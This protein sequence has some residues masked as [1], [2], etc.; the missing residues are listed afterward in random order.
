MSIPWWLDDGGYV[1]P[2]YCKGCDW[3][4]D[5]REKAWGGE[6]CSFACYHAAAVKL[7]ACVDCGQEF[8]GVPGDTKC[9]ECW[10]DGKIYKVAS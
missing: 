2:Q 1:D 9:L 5:Y 6:Y 7:I 3:R 8:E 4:M 10:F